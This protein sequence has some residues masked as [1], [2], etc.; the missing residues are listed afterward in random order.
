MKA[1]SR[2]KVTKMLKEVH[3]LHTSFMVRTT[4]FLLEAGNV[5]EIHV[6]Y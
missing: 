5:L 4:T 2:S 3:S 6:R 1:L